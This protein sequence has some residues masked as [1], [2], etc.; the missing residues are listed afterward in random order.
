MSRRAARADALTTTALPSPMTYFD[1]L[2]VG[3]APGGAGAVGVGG[4][5]PRLG[6]QAG[7]VALAGGR[8]QPA[9]GFGVGPTRSVSTSIVVSSN[10][11]DRAR[12]VFE[13]GGRAFATRLQAAG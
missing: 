8:P 9:I 1:T 3:I 4:G 12:A 6:V 2:A 5:V 10:A 7:V 11:R 13:F